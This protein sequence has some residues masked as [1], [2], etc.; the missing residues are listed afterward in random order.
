MTLTYKMTY[1]ANQLAKYP[2]QKS[3][4]SKVIPRTHTRP[5]ECSTWT[6][7]VV[8]ISVYYCNALYAARLRLLEFYLLNS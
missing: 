8:G 1:K 6:T 7:K 3:L 2:G 4:R 5:N